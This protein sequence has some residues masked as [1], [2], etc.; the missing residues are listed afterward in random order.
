MFVWL[1]LFRAW[2]GEG[3]GSPGKGWGLSVEGEAFLR[4][5]ACRGVELTQ[6]GAGL[7]WGGVGLTRA[8]AGLA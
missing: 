7:P 3:W 4:G 2:P 1:L 8:W 5:G 6:G